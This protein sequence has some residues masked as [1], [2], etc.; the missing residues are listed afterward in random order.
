[1]DNL[2]TP[3]GHLLDAFLLRFNRCV[4]VLLS[5]RTVQVYERLESL[6][7]QCINNNHLMEV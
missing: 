3:L 6:S 5:K 1:M 4:N 2:E 7:M